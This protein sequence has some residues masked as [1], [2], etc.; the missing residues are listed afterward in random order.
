MQPSMLLLLIFFVLPI[1]VP[2]AQYDRPVLLIMFESLSW[3]ARLTRLIQLSNDPS[4]LHW[5]TA[6]PFSS[7]SLELCP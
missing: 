5:R 7:C 2:L 6:E 4:Q 1:S 3:L